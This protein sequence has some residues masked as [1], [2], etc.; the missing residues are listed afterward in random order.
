MIWVFDVASF[1]VQ[2]RNKILDIIS[3]EEMTKEAWQ[4]WMMLKCEFKSNQ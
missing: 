3:A 1:R 2:Y 4:T